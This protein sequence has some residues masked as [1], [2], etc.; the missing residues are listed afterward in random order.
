MQIK[1]ASD[2]SQSMAQSGDA[3]LKSLQ[4]SNF[5]TIDIIVRESIQNA[6]DA[7]IEGRPVT[8]VDYE[9]GNFNAQSLNRHFDEISAELNQRFPDQAEFLSIRDSETC[10]LTG[11]Y[12]SDDSEVL[13]KSNFQ[14]LVFSIGK[15]QEADGA[16]GSWGLGKTS[17]FRMGIGIVIYYTRVKNGAEYEERLIASLIESP[18]DN[19]RL[20]K[21]S[22]R[23]IAWWGTYDESDG[24]KI[25]P[26]TDHRQILEILN[27]FGLPGYESDET[28]TTII[29]PYLKNFKDVD[30]K[31]ENAQDKKLPW[32]V[33]RE[34]AIVTAVQRWYSPRLMNDIYAKKIGNSQ[35]VCT[36]NGGEPIGLFQ[37]LEKP[38]KLMQ[39]LYNA[40]LVGSSNNKQISV[41]PIKMARMGMETPKI[42]AGK[43]AFTIQQKAD[44]SNGD[45]TPLNYIEGSVEEANRPA[46]VAFARKPGMIVKYDV[47]GSW[48]NGVKLNEGQILLAFYVPNSAGKIYR[49]YQ[50]ENHRTLEQYLRLSEKAD[51]ADWFDIDG[52]TLIK[53]LVRLVAKS[54][55]DETEGTSDG[56]AT[57]LSSSLARRFGGWLPPEGFGKAGR[58]SDKPKH[59]K[60]SKHNRVVSIKVLDTSMLANGNIKI[61]FE[62]EMKGKAKIELRIKTQEA[63]LTVL[64]WKKTFEDLPFP[65]AINQVEINDGEIVMDQYDQSTVTLEGSSQRSTTVKGS[66]SLQLISNE[67]QPQIRIL[68]V[69]D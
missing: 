14:K 4:N 16:G 15:N 19:D 69:N 21:S 51:H 36:L 17:Y 9:L 13:N 50:D 12:R 63:D 8:R 20:L 23:G 59:K 25:F 35:L 10:G 27:V 49:K 29:V 58:K 52:I 32:E 39:E 5:S 55:S 1:I 44:L 43:I 31:D 54:L 66:I 33:D 47:N 40:A 3:I 37:N 22:N 56:G 11:D 67:Y 60:T 38:F 65:L 48:S 53:R 45:I 26:I 41:K 30:F 57:L 18:K 24:N 46:I 6:L 68:Q 62:A 7:A 28:G 2:D 61:D 64:N 42:E 34:R